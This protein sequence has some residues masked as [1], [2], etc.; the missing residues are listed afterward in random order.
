MVHNRYRSSQPSGE[1]EVAVD[2]AAALRDR[3][4]DMHTLTVDS[5]DIATWS[6]ARKATLPGRVVWSFEGA[7]LIRDAIADARPDVVHFHNT[8]PLI[9]PAGLRAARVAGA[10]VV[11]TL[12]NYRPLCPAGSLFR[13]GGVCEE[14]LGRAPFPAVRHACYRNSRAATLPLAVA[15][16]LHARTGTWNRYVDTY[17]TPSEFTRGRYVA[18]GWPSDRLT[19]KHNMV[20]DTP[21]RRQGP[22]SGFVCLARLSPEK[23]VGLLLDA[24]AD[25]FP[26]GGEGLTVVGSGELERELREASG[27][28]A[29]VRFAGQLPRAAAL[30]LALGARAVVVPSVWYEVFGRTAAEA[31]ALGVPVVASDLGGLPE[32]VRDG[33]TGLLFSGGSRE[34]LSGCL[35]R[36][37]ASDDLSERL[38]N[39]GRR[40]YER[41]FSP[42]VTTDRLVDI[43]RRVLGTA[44]EPAP[45][46]GMVPA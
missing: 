41:M 20:P 38:G 3:G 25:A 35:K 26:G 42:G 10:R 11:Q 7:R 9:S 16:A 4:V 36:L 44:S 32:V 43:Y 17:I 45:T 21:L 5:D 18:A 8:F 14:C 34:Q 29:G 27:H 6:R 30:E 33:E 22:G 12:H 40:F 23:G 19:V 39:A 46:R 24:W 13:D 37:A 2:E 28:L 1:N 31:S 15:D